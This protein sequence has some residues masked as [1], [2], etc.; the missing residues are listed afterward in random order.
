[1][2]TNVLNLYTSYVAMSANEKLHAGKLLEESALILK[3]TAEHSISNDDAVMRSYLMLKIAE[4]L[5]KQ[6]VDMGMTK[7]Y[8]L[9]PEIKSYT[10]LAFDLAFYYFDFRPNRLLLPYLS[11]VIYYEKNNSNDEY[12]VKLKALF[13]DCLKMEEDYLAFLSKNVDWE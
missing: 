11:R 10:Y 12:F 4:D 1:M 7:Q 3:A 6:A 5:S 9:S 13:A 8:D 2:F